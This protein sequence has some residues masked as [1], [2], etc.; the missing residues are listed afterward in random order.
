MS[1]HSKTLAH[2]KRNRRIRREGALMRRLVDSTKYVTGPELVMVNGL[3]H[4]RAK[5]LAIAE[6]EVKA[7][8]AKLGL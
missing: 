5:K 4:N 1:K 2:E 8:R 7:L 6:R 3:E